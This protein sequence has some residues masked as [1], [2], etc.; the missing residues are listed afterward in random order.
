VNDAAD[1]FHSLFGVVDGYITRAARPLRDE[2][3]AYQE[4]HKP[5]IGMYALIFG[6]R[7][8][9]RIKFKAEPG[10]ANISGVLF[11]SEGVHHAVKGEVAVVIRQ[12]FDRMRCGTPQ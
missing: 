4:F 5:S 10:K 7:I 3:F 2:A 6:A 9:I 12:D 8:V 11:D 1:M